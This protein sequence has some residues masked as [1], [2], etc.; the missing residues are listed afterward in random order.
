MAGMML[1][2]ELPNVA[3][4]SQ[5]GSIH[6]HDL[7]GDSWLMLFSVASDFDATATTVGVH[8]ARTQATGTRRCW[9]LHSLHSAPPPRPHTWRLPSAL[10]PHPTY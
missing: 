9:Q 3:A 5:V 6:L 10:H 2:S 4:T 1:G 8:A 7:I